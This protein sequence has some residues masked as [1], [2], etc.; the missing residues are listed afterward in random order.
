[1]EL[2]PLT[3]E[4]FKR[5]QREYFTSDKAKVAAMTPESYYDDET[6]EE[7]F[8][9]DSFRC[10]YR[11]EDGRGCAVGCAI[12]KELY[13]PQFDA[14]NG[15]G[16]LSLPPDIRKYLGISAETERYY[17]ATQW[18]HDDVA[19]AGILDDQDHFGE[20]FLAQIEEIEKV[21]PDFFTTSVKSLHE[22]GMRRFDY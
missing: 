1:M 4:D 21:E 22:I 18:V 15:V 7:L 12:P 20:A 19:L 13:D 6:E 16:V 11:T 14:D 2:S 3:L 5:I 10:V 17:E 8:Y 9:E